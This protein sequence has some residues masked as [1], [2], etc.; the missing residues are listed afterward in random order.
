MGFLRLDRGG[1]S[2]QNA[3]RKSFA[4]GRP[5]G[6]GPTA[7]GIWRF[8]RPG[9]GGPGAGLPRLRKSRFRSD[10]RGPPRR[11]VKKELN[12]WSS[13]LAR[14][15]RWGSA[16]VGLGSPGRPGARPSSHRTRPSARRRTQAP[17]RPPAAGQAR[18]PAVIGTVDIEAVF[19][20]Y[21]KVKTQ[22]E[23]FKAAAHGQAQR[24]D[25]VPDRGPGRSARSSRS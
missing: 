15:R 2:G 8:P 25:E 12:R 18:R 20:G 4:R 16:C 24:A 22:Q 11:P 7:T 17:P 10:D 5:P 6:G 3:E 21:D 23:E 13:R 14:S 19:K 1:A 9:F